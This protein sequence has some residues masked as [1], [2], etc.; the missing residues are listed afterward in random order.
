MYAGCQDNLNFHECESRSNSRLFPLPRQLCSPFH[1]PPL[2]RPL[3]HTAYSG[4]HAVALE[5]PKQHSMCMLAPLANLLLILIACT[6]RTHIWC[7]CSTMDLGEKK[8]KEMDLLA[9]VRWTQ[10]PT[11]IWIMGHW[12]VSC[13]NFIDATLLPRQLQAD[14]IHKALTGWGGGVLS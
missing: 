5:H 11:A 4:E 14:L 8:K 1:S 13:V 12:L 3:S 6:A 7:S 10:R 9:R 2:S